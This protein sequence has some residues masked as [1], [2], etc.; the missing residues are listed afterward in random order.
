MR[1]Q[2]GILFPGHGVD[3]GAALNGFRADHAAEILGLIFE[4]R[5]RA[6]RQRPA[7]IQRD[8][9]VQRG[10]KRGL[11]LCAGLLASGLGRHGMLLWKKIISRE[12]SAI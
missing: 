2:A 3:L 7:F 11:N 9:L 6:T 8:D 12:S 10:L 1:A 5:K 4:I